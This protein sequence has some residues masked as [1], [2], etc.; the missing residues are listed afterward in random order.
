MAYS[1]LPVAFSL[2]GEQENPF[3]GTKQKKNAAM[4]F[5]DYERMFEDMFNANN[6]SFEVWRKGT[7]SDAT[8]SEL[9]RL[10]AVKPVNKEELFKLWMFHILM[11]YL[12]DK[13]EF[14]E[15]DRF[16][17]LYWKTT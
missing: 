5:W 4:M 6:F 2:S 10:L 9:K 3:D 17:N 7:M 16:N 12:P 14:S 11:E 13:H 1:L 8:K 15:P